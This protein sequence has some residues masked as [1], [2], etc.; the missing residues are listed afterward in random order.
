MCISI[1]NQMISYIKICQ[2][3]NFTLILQLHCAVNTTKMIHAG[4]SFV[5]YYLNCFLGAY[6][7]ANDLNLSSITTAR[8]SAVPVDVD[9]LGVGAPQSEALLDDLLDFREV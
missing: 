5:F 8:G 4:L 3:H 7:Q 2:N 1:S 9:G 6:V